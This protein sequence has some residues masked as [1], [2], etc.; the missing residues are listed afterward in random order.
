M[1]CSSIW[2]VQGP[3]NRRTNPL[4]ALILDVGACN[5][6]RMIG[7]NADITF[8]AMTCHHSF[9]RFHHHCETAKDISYGQRRAKW[10]AERREMERTQLRLQTKDLRRYCY[11][12]S[13]SDSQGN[14]HSETD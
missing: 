8:L 10:E 2:M 9:V 13:D 4:W 11:L 5:L 1:L 7:L 14:S 12:P 6:S 3:D